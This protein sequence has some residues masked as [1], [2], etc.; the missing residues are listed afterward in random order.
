M[1]NLGVSNIYDAAELEW[2][3]GQAREP[4]KVVQ[5]RW[6]Q[7]NGWDWD[8]KLPKSLHAGFLTPRADVFCLVYDLCQKHD[9]RY[10]YVS[11]S[12]HPS[13]EHTG[14]AHYDRSFWTLTG[15]PSLLQHSALISLGE[16]HGLTPEQTLYKLCQLY[17]SCDVCRAYPST[18]EGVLTKDQMEYHTSVRLYYPGSCQEALAV[19]ENT[20]L[21]VDEPEV[22]GLWGAM[23]RTSTA[24]GGQ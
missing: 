3:I 23:R 20:S 11:T 9:I 12:L 5:N 7:G 10:Q 6:Y 21:T 24:A 16:K 13:P 14:M 8:G 22:Q 2:L 15:S 4:V 18:E 1:H 17:A 19:E